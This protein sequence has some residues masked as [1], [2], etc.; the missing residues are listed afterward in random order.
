MRVLPVKIAAG[1][2]LVGQ[3][4]GVSTITFHH[5]ADLDRDHTDGK[6]LNHERLVNTATVPFV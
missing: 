3:E 6:T 4:I 1:L 5:P 2:I